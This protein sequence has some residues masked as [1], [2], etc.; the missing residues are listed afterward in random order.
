[1]CVIGRLL[2]WLLLGA[3]LVALGRDLWSWRLGDGGVFALASAGQ[4]WFDLHRDSL[5][6]VEPALVRH[7]WAPLWDPVMIT[8]LQWPAAAVLGAPGLLLTLLCRQRGRRR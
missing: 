8:I 3:A 7:V 2:G 1:M 5:Q 6:L 4:L